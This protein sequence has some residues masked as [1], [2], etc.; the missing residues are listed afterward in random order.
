MPACGDHSIDRGAAQITA[1]IPNAKEARLVSLCM[2]ISIRLV[3]PITNTDRIMNAESTN[4]YVTKPDRAARLVGITP[5][6]LD[7]MISE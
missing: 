3:E 1:A 7:S 4:I 6:R 2:T 5:H